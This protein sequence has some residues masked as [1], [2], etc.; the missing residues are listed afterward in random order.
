MLAENTIVGGFVTLNRI[1]HLTMHGNVATSGAFASADPVLR[2]FGN[3]SYMTATANMIARDSGA[4]AGPCVTVE[5][6]TDMPTLWRLGNNILANDKAG[7]G[8][9]QV[10]DCTKF[11]IGGN[12]CVSADATGTVYGIDV[13]AVAVN[14]TDALIG[15]GNQFTALA[16]TF[17][18]CV[19]LLANGADIV[20]VSVVGNQ[21]DNTDYGLWAE[22]GGGG[23]TFSGQLMYGTNNFDASTGDI[24]EVGVAITPRIGLN[25]GVFGA[26]MYRGAG[27]P[28]AVVTARI[29]SLYLRTDGSQATTVYVKESGTGNTGWVGIGGQVIIFGVSDT[30]TASAARFMAPGW[31]TVISTTEVQVAATRPGTIRNLRV[32]V[33]AAG[34]DAQTVTYT[35]RKNGVDTALTTT[36]SNDAS[37]NATDTTHSFTVVAGDLLSLGVTKA[38]GV[39][40]GQTNVTAAMELA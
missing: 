24:N 27:S 21:G 7:G 26:N 6:A 22:I 31:I 15:P 25:A 20:N 1:K 34:T 12:I 3:V 9:I 37:G 18:A 33:G 30:G 40:A 10:V 16:S 32:R 8:F 36:I 28:E 4:D 11:S 13:Q 23:G 14:I 2:I 17:D 39:T 29:G 35:V 5:T 19:R 38:A